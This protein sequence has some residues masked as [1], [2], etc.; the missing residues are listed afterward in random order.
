MALGWSAERI[1]VIDDDQGKSGSYS[2]NQGKKGTISEFFDAAIRFQIIA[3]LFAV[4]LIQFKKVDQRQ[5]VNT[6]LSPRVA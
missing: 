5:D 6:G 1:R 4:S 2:D 3:E